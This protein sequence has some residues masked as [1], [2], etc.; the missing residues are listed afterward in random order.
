MYQCIT[1]VPIV[2]LI[3]VDGHVRVGVGWATEWYEH[4]LSTF[5]FSVAADSKRDSSGRRG[6]ESKII[7][8]T[9]NLDLP[10]LIR[11]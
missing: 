6:G 3:I 5:I 10:A 2:T 8:G 11:R 9:P 4:A 1:L 7:A